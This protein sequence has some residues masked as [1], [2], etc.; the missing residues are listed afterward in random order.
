MENREGT[1]CNQVNCREGTTLSEDN[2][3]DATR[4]EENRE[5]ITRSEEKSEG[6]TRC[7]DKV[8]YSVE[9]VPPPHL[10]FLFGLQVKLYI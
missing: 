9:D 6:T 8:I 2:R 4:C 10:C 3:K 1:T 7:K 5:G